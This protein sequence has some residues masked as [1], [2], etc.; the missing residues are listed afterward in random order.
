MPNCKKRYQQKVLMTVKYISELVKKN[1]KYSDESN[2]LLNELQQINIQDQ[3]DV[4]NFYINLQ[5]LIKNFLKMCDDLLSY[6]IP[7]KNTGFLYK[8]PEN[9]GCDKCKY[10]CYSSNE[11]NEINNYYS[12]FQNSADIVRSSAISENPLNIPLIVQIAGL[13]TLMSNMKTLVLIEFI[14]KKDVCLLSL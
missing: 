4:D 13:L 14:S 3:N 11:L 2:L 8:N 1:N 10:I 9:I 12:Q 5:K 7:F 6:F